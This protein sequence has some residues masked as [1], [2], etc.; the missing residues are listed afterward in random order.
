MLKK[1][2]EWLPA[3]LIVGAIILVNVWSRGGFESNTTPT[4]QA[5][6]NSFVNGCV[7]TGGEAL[8]SYC[9]CAYD[10]ILVLHPD[11]ATN[12]QRMERILAEGYDQEETRA[13][14]VCNNDSNEQ[15]LTD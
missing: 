13:M 12:T 14:G 9:G 4:S 1:I 10:K 3:I 6:K 15:V 8:K 2:K 7:G 11:F 5:S